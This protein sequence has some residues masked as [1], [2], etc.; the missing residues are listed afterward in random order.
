MLGVI[1]WG[2]L[3]GFVLNGL[4]FVLDGFWCFFWCCFGDVVVLMWCRLLKVILM[5]CLLI[6]FVFLRVG[7]KCRWCGR[8]WFC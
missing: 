5:F 7:W 3:C 6:M 4:C 2:R 1:F 8:F